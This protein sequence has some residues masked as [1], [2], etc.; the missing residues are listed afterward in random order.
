[1]GVEAKAPLNKIDIYA[2]WAGLRSP[3]L[4]GLSLLYM[5]GGTFGIAQTPLNSEQLALAFS[6]WALLVLSGFII[7]L[8][9]DKQI[10]I[11]TF[12]LISVFWTS[13]AIQQMFVA[14]QE[15]LLYLSVLPVLVAI[16]FV[17]RDTIP[18][19]AVLA[20]VLVIF[21]DSF[22]QQRLWIDLDTLYIG[23]LLAFAAFAGYAL[24]SDSELIVQW[25]VDSQS[26]NFVRAES[27]FNQGEE[28]RKSNYEL[29][30]AN[31]KLRHLTMELNESKQQ[32]EEISRAKSAFLSNM[33]H[34]LRT[35][36][37]M[38][39]GYT[40]SILGMPQM[41]KNEALPEVFRK[42]IELIQS[43]GQYLLTLINDILDLS[44]IESGKFEI[45]PVAF[46]LTVVLQGVMATALGL[47]KD[48]PIQLKPDYP[49]KLPLIWGDPLRI[50]QILLNLMSNA[51]K[52][53]TSGSVTLSVRVNGEKIEIA[54]M[55]T[56]IGIPKEVISTIF[57]RFEQVQKNTN[58]QG[59]G[60]GLDISQRLAHMHGSE[61]TIESTVGVGSS[62]AFELPL[63]TEAQAS[64]FREDATIHDI[65]GIKRFTSITPVVDDAPAEE[66]EVKRTVLIVEDDSV[67]RGLLI[68]L[69]ESQNYAVFDVQ[70]GE[71]V[72]DAASAL[73]PHLIILDIVLPNK[74][75]W[76]VLNELKNDEET[77]TIPVIVLT[78]QLEGAE[79]EKHKA[80]LCLVK[81]F[82]P[83]EILEH[84]KNLSLQVRTEVEN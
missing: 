67:T 56:G 69:F 25:A 41:Y 27:F 73:L 82:S 81:P 65:T 2:E 53:T 66:W 76:T 6:P 5:V 3:T 32:V 84:A 34:E 78:A 31:E 11:S 10:P 49:E 59:T 80:E 4:Y 12:L 42:D 63:A 8:L 19:L 7:F 77:A 18:Q 47:V 13:I 15:N 46:D 64:S 24:V 61:I 55:D 48:K 51:I 1:M 75:G 52:Y 58:I 37:N 79:T 72:L 16:I 9:K 57:D 29:G 28:L 62:F 54:V 68:R 70:N 43:S 26:K 39:I 17:K 21:V 23:A 74:D 83:E 22:V 36:L 40:S 14:Y 50:R 45:N 71:D 44:K 30:N 20:F 38:V 33:S 60:L 35:P